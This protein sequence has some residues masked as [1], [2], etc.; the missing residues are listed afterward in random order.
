M[1]RRAMTLLVI[2]CGLGLLGWK[3]QASPPDQSSPQATVKS[4]IA[5]LVAKN[6]DSVA[7][8]VQGGQAGAPLQ[9]LLNSEFGPTARVTGAE[10]GDIVVEANGDQAKVAAEVVLQSAPQSGREG[11]KVNL[12]VVEIFRL[13]RQGEKWQLVPDERIR[14]M[15]TQPAADESRFS[16]A[17]SIRWSRWPRCRLPGKTPGVKPQPKPSKSGKSAKKK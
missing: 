16:S 15:L 3:W 13:Q 6:A 9:S 2:G 8:C 5:A 4:F 7:A 12:A 11:A 14:K 10:V 17:R 1:K